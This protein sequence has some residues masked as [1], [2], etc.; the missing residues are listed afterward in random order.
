MANFATNSVE[1]ALPDDFHHHLRDGDVLR[2]IVHHATR[3]FGRIIAMPNIKPPVR[4]LEEAQQYHAR[5]MAH[6][7]ADSFRALMTIYLTDFTTREEI[8]RSYESG[9]SRSR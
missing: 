8:I 1:L 2:E 6:A 5:I 7:P 3:S 9:T 4:S